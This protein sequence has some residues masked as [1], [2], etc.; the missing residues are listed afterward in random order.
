MLKS[1][2]EGKP[3]ESAP[4]KS[5][6][7]PFVHEDDDEAPISLDVEQAPPLTA[8]RKAQPLRELSPN[9]SQRSES[10]AQAATKDQDKE[11]FEKSSGDTPTG[12][13]A[14]RPAQAPDRQS[15][16]KENIAQPMQKLTS[17][18][19]TLI[20]HSRVGPGQVARVEPQKRKHR[21]LG[22]NLSGTSLCNRSGSASA[23]PAL[24]DGVPE[25]EVQYSEADGFAPSKQ[26]TV[27]PPSTQLGYDSP[28]AE[29]LRKQMSLKMGG[30]MMDEDAG[31]HVA[32]VGTVRDSEG[33]ARSAAT[34]AAR[35]AGARKGMRA[36][37]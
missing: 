31:K 18:L 6:P 30:K 35:A 25:E 27:L 23:S 9:A 33:V 13:P 10:A 32:S 3:S 36:R 12:S 2:S 7:G 37:T 14:K 21:P 28:E 8:A 26:E 24:P 4:R 16:S 1:G 34:G 19:A 29:E 17:D 20:N 15:P 5:R 22:R 11:C